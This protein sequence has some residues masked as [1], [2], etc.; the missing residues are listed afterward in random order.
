MVAVLAMTLIGLDRP[1]NGGSY[2]R[3]SSRY[4]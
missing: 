4:L 1:G 3:R 2:D